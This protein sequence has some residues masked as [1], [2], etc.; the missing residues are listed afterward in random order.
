MANARTVSQRLIAIAAGL[1]VLLMLTSPGKAQSLPKITIVVDNAWL[2][3]GPSLT[4]SRTLPVAKGQFYDVLAR[5]ADNAWWQLVVPGQKS[6]GTWLFADLGVLYSSSLEAAPVI[7]PAVTPAR[8][9][10]GQPGS[11]ASRPSSARSG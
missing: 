7:T 1:G 3:R 10:P 4:A 9:R 8:R 2:R 6:G 11:R 5:T